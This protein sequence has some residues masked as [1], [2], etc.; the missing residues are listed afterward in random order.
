MEIN[1]ELHYQEYKLYISG[2]NDLLK[3]EPLKCGYIG[4]NLPMHT[5]PSFC[6]FYFKCNI[7][8]VIGRFVYMNYPSQGSLQPLY[9]RHLDLSA[10]NWAS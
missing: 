7:F 2:K 3:T 6:L 8:D 5:S 10:L 9:L 4:K 1:V